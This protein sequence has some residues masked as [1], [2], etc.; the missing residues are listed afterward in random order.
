MNDLELY[1]HSPINPVLK[2]LIKYY[3]IIKSSNEIDI[4]GKLIP[5]NNIDLIINLSTPIKYTN[6]ANEKVYLKSHFNGIQSNYRTVQQK[7]ILDIVGISFYPTGFYP[8]V[9]VPLSEFQNKII[10]IDNVLHG[11]EREIERIA[12]IESDHKR[13]S[14]IEEILMKIIDFKLIP[15][16]M[17]DLLT[18]D[19]TKYGDSINIKK[20]CKSHGI[21][22]KTLERNFYKYI[23]T[24]PKSFLQVTKFQNTMK[25]LR[26]GNFSS[27]TQI[28]YEYNYYDQ[29]H[30]I[31]SF[32]T[33]MGNTPSKQR[34]EN[35]LIIDILPKT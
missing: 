13:I 16:K 18:N 34:K 23:G 11:F 29:T 3:W 30:F 25:R 33:F 1:K 35:D 6:G 7:G 27:M 9:K 17:L 14:I 26:K 24:T 21:N 12:G 5:M 19:F 15:D 28:G 8:L 20:Y 2:K 4:Q 22:Q 10:Q 31:N 32:K